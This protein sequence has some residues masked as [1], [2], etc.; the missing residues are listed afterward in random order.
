MSLSVLAD[1]RLL[2]VRLIVGEVAIPLGF[3]V[4]LFKVPVSPTPATDGAILI[5]GE[6]DF[7]GYAPVTISTWTAVA[8]VTLVS[9]ST[10]APAVFT[11]SLPATVG[12]N[13]YGWFAT[14]LGDDSAVLWAEFFFGAPLDMSV[15]GQTISVRM[16]ITDSSEF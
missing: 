13:V 6:A 7:S 11:V 3:K 1:G 15:P 12:N 5:A 9:S 4:R 2:A 10:S 8:D 14:E 16:K